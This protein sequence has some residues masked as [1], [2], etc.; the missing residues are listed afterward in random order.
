MPFLSRLRISNA[1]TVTRRASVE[2][3]P[4]DIPITALLQLVC[5]NL[6]LSPY[7]CMSSISS[8][9]AS[10]SFLSSGTNGALSKYLFNSKVR[11]FNSGQVTYLYASFIFSSTFTSNVDILLLS[12]HILS[13]SISAYTASLVNFL[14]SASTVPFSHIRLCAPNTISCVDS[15]SPAVE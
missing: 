14:A 12:E 6:F 9:L 15:P 8:H 7:V 11:F 1:L 2:S 10:L 5:S 3:S 4:P 13:T